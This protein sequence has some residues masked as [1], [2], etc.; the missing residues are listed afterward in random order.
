MPDSAT[1]NDGGTG[2]GF[3]AEKVAQDDLARLMLNHL[4]EGYEKIELDYSEVGPVNQSTLWATRPGAPEISRFPG[5]RKVYDAAKELR[6]VMYHESA[7]TW[8]SMH[9]TVTA[10]HSVDTTYNYDD[11]P[12]RNFDYAPNTYTVDLQRFPRDETHIPGWLR[13]LL[14]EDLRDEA[15]SEKQL[16]HYAEE[17]FAG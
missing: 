5:R 17:G 16:P 15:G 6:S 12:W 13:E 10:E 8:F 9:M 2:G 11:L 1:P 14:A 4:P 3:F 7:G